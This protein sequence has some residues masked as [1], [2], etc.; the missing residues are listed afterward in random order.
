M[1]QEQAIPYLGQGHHVDEWSGAVVADK[2]RR[3]RQ[4]Q[5]QGEGSLWSCFE[6][7]RRRLRSMR[8]VHAAVPAT[9]P[10]MQHA[11]PML[12]PSMPPPLPQDC[13][14][15]V[16]RLIER[17]KAPLPADR[18]T[19]AAVVAALQSMAQA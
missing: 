19:A 10:P 8:F 1:G 4:Q 16:A 15:A 6:G 2:G 7:R 5:Q 14:E 18:P 11:R 13:P 12:A 17:C 3:Q 9:W